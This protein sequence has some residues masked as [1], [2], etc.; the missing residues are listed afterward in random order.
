MQNIRK[1][2]RQSHGTTC[3][4]PFCW[5]WNFCFSTTTKSRLGVVLGH[6][7]AL[8]QGKYFRPLHA[9]LYITIYRRWYRVV[10]KLS[11]YDTSLVCHFQCSSHSLNFMQLRQ[12]HVT[13]AF[14][15]PLSWNGTQHFPASSPRWREGL[16]RWKQ[17]RMN[18]CF[19]KGSSCWQQGFAGSNRSKEDNRNQLPQAN[20]SPA[21]ASQDLP[22]GNAAVTDLIIKKVR[23]HFND[24]TQQPYRYSKLADTQRFAGSR[25]PTSESCKIQTSRL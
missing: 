9:L 10:S 7:S 14:F 18:I 6:V 8:W 1:S 11:N 3:C 19:F 15:F 22:S 20:M 2:V 13:N 12:L 4:S 24:F 21:G 23:L 17:V 16:R 5:G 25:N